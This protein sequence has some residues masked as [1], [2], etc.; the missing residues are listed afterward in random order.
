[1]TVSTIKRRCYACGAMF[2]AE[3]IPMQESYRGSPSG[4]LYMPQSVQAW[5]PRGHKVQIGL[6]V[7]E[8]LDA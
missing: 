6:C 2:Y 8:G 4:R 5:C 7:P 3:S 1:M